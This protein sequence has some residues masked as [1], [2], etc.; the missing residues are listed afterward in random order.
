MSIRQILLRPIAKLAGWHATRQ[1][2]AF[3]HCHKQT[4]KVQDDLLAELL[5]AH[6][7][8]AFARDHDLTKV[9]SYDDFKAALPIRTY[10]DFRP[11]VNRV[12]EGETTAMLPPGQQVLMFSMTSGTTGQPKHIPVTPRF[13]DDIRRGWNVFGINVLSQHQDAW[14]RPIVQISS[15]MHEQ[16]SPT[17]LPC[18]AISGLLAATQ[19][20]IVRR[21]YIVPPWYADVTDPAT[22]F[23]TILRYSIAHDIAFITTANP[24]STLKLI[25]TGQSHS[26][27]LIRD[28]AEG[29][30]TPPSNVLPPSASKKDLTTFSPNP[31]LAKRLE[32]GIAADGELLPRHFWNLSF[33]T[34]WTGGTMRLY[35]RRLRRLFGD[36]A[37]HD[38]GL[39]ASEGR[40]SIPME[41]GTAEGIAEITSN[42]LEFIP[43]EERE[44]DNPITLRADELD[45]GGE[46]F[47]VISNWTGLMRYN[48]DDRVRVTGHLGQSPIFEFLCRGLHTANI[49]GEKITEHQVVHAMRQARRITG[50]NTERFLLQGRFA[51]TPYYELRIEI[52]DHAAAKTMAEHLDKELAEINIEY[53]SKRK[54]GRLDPIRPVVLPAGSLEEAER[55]HIHRRNGRSE[56]YKHQYLLTDILDENE[57]EKETP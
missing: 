46:Y 22:R 54:S 11:Y 49:T 44:K 9:R 20:K 5:D 18:G 41:A 40:F 10:E 38:I 28:I 4:R 8:T 1:L 55:K 19:K 23:Y 34:N 32:A 26:Q 14:V 47:L 2:G 15:S 25:E 27:R 16:Q 17:G 29:T 52:A 57:E 21:M 3:L 35:I 6:S 56:Q 7:E 12:L 39:V 13:L 50:C 53:A 31:A 43:A 51:A 48:L 45:V 36:V 30:F 33:L 37:I 24:S 42:V